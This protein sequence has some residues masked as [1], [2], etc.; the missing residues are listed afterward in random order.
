MHFTTHRLFYFIVR[1]EH[2]LMHHF[3]GSVLHVHAP[4]M[5]FLPR[6]QRLLRE[7]KWHFMLVN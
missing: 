1:Y 7:A 3:S 4:F 5:H 2:A 6:S